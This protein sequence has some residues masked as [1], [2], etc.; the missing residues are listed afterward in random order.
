MWHTNGHTDD[1]H[2]RNEDDLDDDGYYNVDNDNDEE[3]KVDQ[4]LFL[5]GEMARNLL[6]DD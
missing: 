5:A 4:G 6:L 3:D 1:S 2:E